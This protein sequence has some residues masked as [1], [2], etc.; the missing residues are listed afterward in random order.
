MGDVRAVSL[1]TARGLRLDGGVLT[2]DASVVYKEVTDKSSIM[3][4]PEVF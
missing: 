2:S 3:I 1:L 4:V